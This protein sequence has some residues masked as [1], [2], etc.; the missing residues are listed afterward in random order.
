MVSVEC[1]V[2]IDS[3]YGRVAAVYVFDEIGYFVL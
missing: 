3:S 1:F 2:L